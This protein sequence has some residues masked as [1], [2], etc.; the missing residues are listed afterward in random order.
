MKLP[1][2]IVPR[3][4]KSCLIARLQ[5]AIASTADVWQG[6]GSEITGQE[7]HQCLY[8]E[9]KYAVIEVNADQA[10]AETPEIE[11]LEAGSARNAERH[12]YCRRDRVAEGIRATNRHGLR[13]ASSGDSARNLRTFGTE[14][15][16]DVKFVVLAFGL[17]H[18][19]FDR[20]F[21]PLSLNSE[22]HSD[23]IVPS[24]GRC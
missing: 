5:Q 1:T 7:V 17:D 21:N 19:L 16:A 14:D 13:P 8:R 4:L 3:K 24:L 18:H 15:Q 9:S 2:W 12:F 11:R 22:L 10:I 6:W 23:Q 20:E